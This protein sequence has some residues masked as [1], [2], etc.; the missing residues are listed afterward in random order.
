MDPNWARGNAVQRRSVRAFHGSFNARREL[1]LCM[2]ISTRYKFRSHRSQGMLKGLF[3][4]G[5]LYS[6]SRDSNDFSLLRCT[7]W[8]FLFFR[9]LQPAT[10]ILGDRTLIW[11]RGSFGRVISSIPSAYLHSLV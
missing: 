9:R 1:F 3:P 6:V 10:L 11:L 5:K 8:T 4:A 7:R 2:L